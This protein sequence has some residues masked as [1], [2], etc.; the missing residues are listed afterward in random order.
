MSYGNNQNYLNIAQASG[1]E[2]WTRHFRD[3]LKVPVPWTPPTLHGV[4]VGSGGR[5]IMYAGV[6][7]GQDMGTGMVSSLATSGG[8]GDNVVVQAKATGGSGGHKATGSCSM[9]SLVEQPV[10]MAESRLVNQLKSKQ[11]PQKNQS[12]GAKATANTKRKAQAITKATEDIFSHKK[13]K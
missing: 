9:T 1:P 7:S 3:R 2:V 13:K 6:P 10:D 5:G 4:R 11:F 12:G 8:G